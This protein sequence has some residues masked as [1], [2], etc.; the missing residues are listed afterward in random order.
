MRGICDVRNNRGTPAGRANQRA[1]AYILP[2]AMGEN[3]VGIESGRD[4]CVIS[5]EKASEGETEAGSGTSG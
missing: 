5:S 4:G 3:G 2:I 1:T